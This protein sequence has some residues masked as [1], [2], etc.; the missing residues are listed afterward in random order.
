MVDGIK[1]GG[2]FQEGEGCDRP[3]SHVERKIVLNMFSISWLK[4]SHKLHQGEFGAGLPLYQNLYTN[5][6]ILKTK[7]FSIGN[8]WRLFLTGEI[9]ECLVVFATILSRLF[10]RHLILRRLRA[11][12]G[13]TVVKTTSNQGICSQKSSFIHAVP[14]ESLR[15]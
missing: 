14:S 9:Y 8:Q 12:Q 11:K 10:W 13:N 2:E 5:W 7:Q 1:S 3:F 4:C 15:N 6:T